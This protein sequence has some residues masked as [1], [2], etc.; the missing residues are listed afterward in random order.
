MIED[1]RPY[2]VGESDHF[3]NKKDNE[4]YFGEIRSGIRDDEGRI[5][6]CLATEEGVITIQVE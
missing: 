3:L 6:L 5:F 4:I 1:Y 2:T